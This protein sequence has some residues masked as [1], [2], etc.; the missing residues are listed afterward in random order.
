MT[1]NWDVILKK[2]LMRIFS[3][4]ILCF[5]YLLCFIILL[6][7]RTITRTLGSSLL[8][9]RSCRDARSSCHTS[10]SQRSHRDPVTFG[11]GWLDDTI[12]RA[13]RGLRPPPA[14]REDDKASIITFRGRPRS[15]FYYR[16]CWRS[17][18]F[19]GMWDL[20]ESQ[21]LASPVGYYFLEAH[22]A[23]GTSI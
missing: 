20:R 11:T 5:Y 10:C 9:R 22:L 13:N 18:W 3:Y 21:Y 1:T 23:A 19:L 7:A 12:A 16:G 2:E 17:I 15:R 6:W 4:F 14:L 8:L